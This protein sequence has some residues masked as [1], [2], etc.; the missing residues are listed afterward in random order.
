MNLK[1]VRLDV[2]RKNTKITWMGYQVN[3][4]SYGQC[5]DCSVYKI[6]LNK[7]S[8]SIKIRFSVN[9]SMRTWDKLIDIHEF[10][11][12]I[13]V[14]TENWNLHV[15]VENPKNNFTSETESSRSW[16][17]RRKD[18]LRSV[19]VTTTRNL[20][21][22]PTVPRSCHNR[23]SLYYTGCI[24]YILKEYRCSLFDHFI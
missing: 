14:I 10:Y 8:F 17:L 7:M 22:N 6:L 4:G 5:Y 13:D 9:H 16:I 2:Q 20:G 23:S 11:F 15:C 1:K 3:I 12:I 21:W 24:H 18:S 19:M